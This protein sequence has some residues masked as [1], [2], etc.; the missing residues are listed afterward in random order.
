VLEF[1]DVMMNI[2]QDPLGSEG[3]DNPI[4]QQLMETVSALQEAMATSK[5]EQERLM[6]EVRVEQVLTKTK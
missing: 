1:L 6:A 4:I 5:A 3:N 2:R